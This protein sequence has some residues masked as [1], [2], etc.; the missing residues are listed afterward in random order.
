MSIGTGTAYDLS[1]RGKEAIGAGVDVPC[2]PLSAMLEEYNVTWIN[3]YSLDVVGAELKVL[4]T[5]DFNK[6]KVDVLMVEAEFFAAQGS[7]YADN[8]KVEAVRTLIK[9]E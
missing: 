6:V 5:F 4:E 2:H 7:V 8:A 3:F 1:T 9:K